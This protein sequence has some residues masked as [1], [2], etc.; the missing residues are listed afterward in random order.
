MI[1]WS[2]LSNK[3]MRVLGWW[4]SNSPYRDYSGIIAE[5]AIR[6]GKTLVMSLSFVLWAMETSDRTK[7]AICG[8]TVG[9]LRRN[10]ITDLKEVLFNRGYKVVDRQSENVLIVLKGNKKNMFYM[11]GG[12][13]ERSQDL[14]QGITLRGILL[15]E[16]AL[17]PRSFVEQ[18]MGRCS[19][20]GSKY[21]FN[22][23]PEGPK[24]WFYVEH[25]LE[26]DR[27]KY[28]RL[29]FSLEDNLSLSEDTI[30]RY[31]TMF[32][33]IFYKRFVLGEWAF[34]NGVIYD[35]FDDSNTYSN[36][37]REKV[38]PISILENDTQNGG[39]A[40]Y[41][42]DYGI[43]N[44]MVFLEGYKIRVKDDPIPHFY[45][46][47][48]YYWDSRKSMAQKT[49][50]EY[51][52][53]LVKFINN[54]HYTSVIIDP[55][56]SSLIAA[57]RQAGIKIIKADNEVYEG[58][59]VVYSLMSTGHIHINKDNCPNLINELGLYIWNEKRGEIGKEEPVKQ[60]DH[61]C[62][63]LRYM[64]KTTTANYEVFR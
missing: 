26:A 51:I 62:D 37:E 15:D 4:M 5:G 56:A 49:D 55:S 27:R 35:C 53:D 52:D 10:V 13:D 54:K 19:V 41:G 14:I 30:Q 8:K 17:M 32:S 47:N 24:H 20:E 46:D 16:V 60:Y 38:L 21:W 31:K 29:H 25:I 11:F 61:A 42:S 57:G 36:E 45:I 58:I 39:A 6:S 43:Y 40:L 2:P 33:G 64:I 9:S 23:N 44:P 28:L 59:R 1:K 34:A 22:C 18:A 50:K 7:Y 3:Q 63:A 48:E 12:R